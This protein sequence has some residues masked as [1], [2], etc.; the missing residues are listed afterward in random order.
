MLYSQKMRKKLI[1]SFPTV[2]DNDKIPL[3]MNNLTN[4]NFMAKPFSLVSILTQ[5]KGLMEKKLTPK[6]SCDKVLLN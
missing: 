6:K 2:A 3:N 1:F 5:R 4:I